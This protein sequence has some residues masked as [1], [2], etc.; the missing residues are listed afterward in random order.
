LGM[1]SSFL[2]QVIRSSFSGRLLIFFI[3]TKV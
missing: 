2:G 3:E 1:A